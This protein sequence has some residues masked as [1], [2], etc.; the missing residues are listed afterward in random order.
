MSTVTPE[1]QAT[2]KAPRSQRTTHEVPRSDWGGQ[3]VQVKSE[4]EGKR[5]DRSAKRKGEG[6]EVMRREL[7]KVLGISAAFLSILLSIH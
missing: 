2:R 3:I 4:I 1:R 5:G 7:N 6:G